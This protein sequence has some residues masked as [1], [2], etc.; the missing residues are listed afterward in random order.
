MRCVTT[1]GLARTLQRATRGAA[2]PVNLVSACG[3]DTDG[4]RVATRVIARRAQHDE[5]IPL[6]TE[7][8][9]LRAAIGKWSA[10]AWN[11]HRVLPR[12][13]EQLVDEIVAHVARAYPGRDLTR[14]APRLPRPKES[15][16]KP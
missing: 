1:W 6:C 9:S 13:A 14:R 3:R 5:A 2:V 15:A 16:G 4:D 8:A 12:Y 7:I 11:P 10:I